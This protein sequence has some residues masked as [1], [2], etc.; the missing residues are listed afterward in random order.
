MLKNKLL[1]PHVI[2]RRLLFHLEWC[3]VSKY[4]WFITNNLFFF[5]SIHSR[6]THVPLDPRN[7][8]HWG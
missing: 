4:C 2:P 3:V 1:L 7:L 8:I 5:L 6:I